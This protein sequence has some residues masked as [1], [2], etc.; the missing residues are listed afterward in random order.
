[1]KLETLDQ[2]RD[3]AYS[4]FN[5]EFCEDE[6]GY[7]DDSFMDDIDD[8]YVDLVK[9]INTQR[10]MLQ[11]V[12]FDIIENWRCYTKAESFTVSDIN[13]YDL[14]F[15]ANFID[16]EIKES[17]DAVC[18]SLD[19]NQEPP[20]DYE[21]YIPRVAKGQLVDKATID[22][23]NH[24]KFMKGTA[25]LTNMMWIEELGYYLVTKGEPVVFRGKMEKL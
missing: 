10:L 6:S 16:P 12:T 5:C 8:E 1:M 11:L 14:Y 25:E 21:P 7:A 15:S 4:L 18:R 19:A 9:D 24:R 2:T 20:E 13:N 22:N 17:W 3:F 23:P